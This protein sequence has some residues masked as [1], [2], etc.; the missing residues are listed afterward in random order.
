M[1]RV[2]QITGILTLEHVKTHPRSIPRSI[3]TEPSVASYG[4]HHAIMMQLSS[5]Y[6]G[7]LSHSLVGRSSKLLLH[8]RSR[9]ISR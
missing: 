9:S 3:T 2:E 7:F 6:F 1:V 8:P 4:M 5:K